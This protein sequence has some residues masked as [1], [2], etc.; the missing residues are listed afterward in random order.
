[1]LFSQHVFNLF[2]NSE[3]SRLITIVRFEKY[4]FDGREGIMNLSCV[5]RSGAKL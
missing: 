1:M 4:R 5:R 2:S 3:Y